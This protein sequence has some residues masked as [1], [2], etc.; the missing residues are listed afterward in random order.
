MTSMPAFRRRCPA[1]GFARLWLLPLA[2]L[3]AAPLGQAVTLLD[4]GAT[5]KLWRGKKT[6]TRPDYWAW[7]KP[8]HDDS[9]WETAP[10]PVFYGENVNGG[11]ELEDMKS[12]YN[13]FFL[14]R[15]F[16]APDPDTITSMTLRA[17]V[18]DGFVA[19]INGTEVARH[20]VEI[21]KP[22]YSSAAS[23]AA[24]EPLRFR[25]YALKNLGEILVDGENTIAVIVLNQ[26]RT[27]PDALFDARLTAVS[28]ESVPPK[29]ATV[30]PPPGLASDLGQ[31]SVTFTEP[32]NGVDATD[33]LANGKPA[34]S[35]EGSGRTWVFQ[36]AGLPQG[37]VRITWAKAHGI[38]D[39]AQTPN[40]FQETGNGNRWKYSHADDNPPHVRRTNPPAGLTVKSLDTVEVEFSMPVSGVD[41]DDLLI[42]GTPAKSVVK[43]SG[44]T[45]ILMRRTKPSPK[46]L[47][48]VS[49]MELA[50]SAPRPYR[51]IRPIARPSTRPAMTRFHSVIS[52]QAFMTLPLN[53]TSFRP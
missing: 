26:R 34:Q 29:V 10:T 7:L 25:N 19:Y 46:G 42:N 12:R 53:T 23:K 50:V 21:E 20:N 41:A 52:V 28:V 2:L 48:Q 18:D 36:L 35:V 1:R 6:P 27:S 22:R 8:D 4:Y 5:W 31:V 43:I 32:V 11:T 39:Q 49:P 30:D 40:T 16:D 9:E 33:L 14:R 47:N 24:S 37:K 44:T 17:K 38:T 15:K 51:M 45:S 3:L 13:S